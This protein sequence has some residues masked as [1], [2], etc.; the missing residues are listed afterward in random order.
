LKLAIDFENPQY[1][2][3]F[4]EKDILYVTIANYFD[5]TDDDSIPLNVASEGAYRDDRALLVTE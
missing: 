1:L 5:I 2:S 4:K 3:H